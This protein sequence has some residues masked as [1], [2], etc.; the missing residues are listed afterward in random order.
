[1][2][3]SVLVP[4]DDGWAGLRV[5]VLSPTPSFPIDYGNRRRIH[6]LC[7]R[8]KDLGAEIHYLH[9]PTEEEW[10]ESVPL[11]EQRRMASEW[12]A[13]YVSPVTRPLYT[14]PAAKPRAKLTSRLW[15]AYAAT[16]HILS[17]LH[18]PRA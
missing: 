2:T 11:A 18:A 6:F 15:W 3:R 1:M 8:L 12:D 14:P 13:Y 17:M 16:P 5:L 4:S 10:G 9:Y 7:R